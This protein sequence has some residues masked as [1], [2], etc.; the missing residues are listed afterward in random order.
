MV[1]EARVMDVEEAD[2]A[3]V[4]VAMAKRAKAFRLEVAEARVVVM[5]VEEEVGTGEVVKEDLETFLATMA[6]SAEAHRA[7]LAAV[8]SVAVL[9]LVGAW[10]A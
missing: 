9:D 8:V 3:T 2:L 1:A 5:D 7:V 10:G 6:E 4:M